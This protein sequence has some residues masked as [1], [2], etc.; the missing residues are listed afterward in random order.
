MTY[1]VTRQSPSNIPSIDVDISQLG[2]NAAFIGTAIGTFLSGII[3]CQA[4]TYAH[5]NNDRWPLRFTVFLMIAVDL[6]VTISNNLF[7]HYFTISHFGNMT[8]LYPFIERNVFLTIEVLLSVTVIFI[9]ELFFATHV[10]LL[11]RTHWIVPAV[12]ASDLCL[13]CVHSRIRQVVPNTLL[14]AKLKEC[15]VAGAKQFGNPY[16]TFDRSSK[17]DF[18]LGGSLSAI[19]DILVTAALLWSF[20]QSRT[21]ITKT[22]SMLQTLFKYTVTRGV[23]VTVFQIV[24]IIMF[25]ARTTT[26]EWSSLQLIISKVYVITMVA[27]LNSRQSIRANHSGVITVSADFG[28]SSRGIQGNSI[29]PD[30]SGEEHVSYEMKSYM[31]DDRMGLPHSQHPKLT[32]LYLGD[33]VE[34]SREPV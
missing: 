22:D 18:G 33:R 27:M 12:I 8:K 25:L 2:G 21:G 26:L 11:K 24:Y 31:Q 29:V 3:V 7:L 9:V 15:I 28:T 30:S 23:L 13:R 6:G 16:L 10:Y 19:S 20:R 14:P 34:Q 5:S 4:F 17:I 1:L 32:T